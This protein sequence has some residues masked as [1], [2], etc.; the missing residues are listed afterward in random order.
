GSFLA[1]LS[2]FLNLG[3]GV[4]P[5]S[6]E[7]EDGGFDYVTGQ[8]CADLANGILDIIVATEDEFAP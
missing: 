6:E 8:R 5:L 2:E 7:A 3:D 1:V 4:V